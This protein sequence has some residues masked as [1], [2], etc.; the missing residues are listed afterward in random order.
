MVFLE[1]LVSGPVEKVVQRDEYRLIQI[2]GLILPRFMFLYC[3][4]RS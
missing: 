3:L 1:K 2:F 4:K